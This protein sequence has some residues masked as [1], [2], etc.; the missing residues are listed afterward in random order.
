[1]RIDEIC[2]NLNVD[3]VE[4]YSEDDSEL[5]DYV[6]KRD[7]KFVNILMPPEMKDLAEQL[8]KLYKEKV[9]KLSEI[10]YLKNKRSI[11]RRDI[12][13]Y[14]IYLQKQLGEGNNTVYFHLSLVAQLLK[15]SY[16]IELFE[17]QGIKSFLDFVDKLRE[18]NTKAAKNLLSDNN[19][20]LVYSKI[21]YLNEQGFIHPK[22]EKMKE[23]LLDYFCKHHEMRVIIFANF[24]NTTKEIFNYLSSSSELR[25]IELVGQKE[26]LKQS[27]QIK[28]IE[29]F[30][31]GKYNCLITTSIGEEGLSIKEA[32]LAVFYDQTSM[33][34]RRIQRSG[35][36]GRVKPGKIIYLITKGTSD[37]SLY[38]AS[39]YGVKKMRI[40]LS[41]MKIK[42]N[43]LGEFDG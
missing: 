6:Q 7:V 38:W 34:V 27:E 36:V 25:P 35:R 4:I 22:M 17:T 19:F 29:E 37:E 5:K 30:S 9:S 20:M 41:K 26:G 24:R 13:A 31:D 23:M 21:K 32:D 3:N 33:G 2:K 28:R 1:V 8:R 42:D 15:L 43:S 10:S 39:H 11:N 12:I 40:I 14:Q 18:D 16:C